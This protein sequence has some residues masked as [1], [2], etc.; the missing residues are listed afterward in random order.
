MHEFTAPFE[1][2]NKSQA[3]IGRLAKRDQLAD[4]R[5]ME[6]LP[7]VVHYG[8]FYDHSRLFATIRFGWCPGPHWHP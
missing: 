4:W 5:V 1:T 2:R 7:D 3:T 8:H 6:L